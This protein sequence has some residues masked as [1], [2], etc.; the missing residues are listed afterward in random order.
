L[1]KVNGKEIEF[2]QFPNG[3]TNMNHLSFP[4]VTEQ[5][6]SSIIFKYENDGDL[7]KLLFVKEYLDT[8]VSEFHCF[9]LTLYH[10]PYGRMDRSENGS[11]FTLKYVADFINRM[12][13]DGISIIEPHSDVTLKLIYD[14]IP[15]Y[16]TKHLYRDVLKETDFNLETDYIMFPDK[17][18]RSRYKD[19]LFPNI[20]TGEK[21]RNFES[22]RIESLD[23]VGEI[24]YT[25]D[26]VLIMDDLSSFGGTFIMSAKKLRELGFE[27]VYLLVAH[28]E[29]SVFKG[30]LFDH[31]DKLFTTDSMLT[32]QNNWENKR[33]ES[34]LKIYKLEDLI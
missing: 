6:G 10:A 14:S 15:D 13:F 33:F 21:V 8:L 16:T 29:N 19:I 2:T 24:N 20:L 32:E 22:G 30:D 3:E 9:H 12:E 11:P 25:P 5:C 26:K 1:I 28:A 34:K 27:E 7:I 17:G 31:I 4:D 23:I 18:A